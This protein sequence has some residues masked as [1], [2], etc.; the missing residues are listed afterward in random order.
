MM[1]RLAIVVPVFN[2]RDQWLSTLLDRFSDF[3]KSLE[4]EQVQLYIVNDGSQKGLDLNHIQQVLR[5]HPD[6]HWMSYPKNAGKG[7]ALR[8]AISQIQSEFIIYTDVD[9]P[10]EN[11][12]MLSIW[13]ALQN[14]DVAVGVKNED[15]YNS[16]PRQRRFISKTLQRLIKIIYPRLL[17]S[18][19][20]CG[21]KGMNQAGKA[22]FLNTSINRYLFDLEFIYLLS[23]T[24]LKQTTV[25][26]KLRPGIEFSH[27]NTRVLFNELFNFF[28]I[29]LKKS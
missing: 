13:K 27:M 8:Y 3:K 17:S 29:L 25:P 24:K 21:L 1:F 7:F 16:L 18:D 9:M 12:S 26:V 11:E 4:I 15:Y 23:R 6:V 14:Q 20:Q 5:C 28:N 2:P 10:F 19:T 22:V